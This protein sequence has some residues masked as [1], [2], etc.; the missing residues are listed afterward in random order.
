MITKSLVWNEAVAREVAAVGNHRRLYLGDHGSVFLAGNQRLPFELVIPNLLGECLTEPLADLIFPATPRVEGADEAAAE[1]LLADMG[2]ADVLYPTAVR[3]SYAGHAVWKLVWD[4]L[5]GAPA[6]VLWGA[7]DDEFATFTPDGRTVN[8]WYSVAVNDVAYRVR[9]MHVVRAGGTTIHN[10]AFRRS[11]E[12]VEATP[13]PWS[14]VAGAWEP[15]AQPAEELTVQGLT[16]P[17]AF[18]LQ[19]VLGASDYTLSRKNIQWRMILVE[20][21]RNFSVSLTTVP[22]LLIPPEAVNPQTGQLD[23]EQLIFRIKRPGDGNLVT[24]DLK[25]AVTSLGDS[26]SVLQNLWDD[27]N[28][29][30]PISPIFYGKAVGSAA[31][32]TAL[33]LSLLG[34]E[35]AVQRRRRVYTP[36]TAW[37][38]AFAA[39]LRRVYAGDTAPAPAEFALAWPPAIPEDRDAVS[40]RIDRATRGGWMSRRQAVHEQHPEWTPAQVEAELAA[41]GAERV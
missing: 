20:S 10:A 30:S 16:L 35:R 5:R 17:P 8:F 23:W 31:S 9:E 33:A 22:Q 3:I 25:Q 12:T 39:Q 34:T 28:A 7:N 40:Q 18:R 11:G 13:A 38:V 24:V 27:W 15:G 19:N 2:W 1:A 4:E 41:I 26:G 37:A 32:G 36:A 21:A 14:A 29:I 6:L